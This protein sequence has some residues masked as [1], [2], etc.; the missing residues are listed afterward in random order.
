MPTVVRTVLQRS[1]AIN[2][3]RK[4]KNNAQVSAPQ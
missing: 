1:L 2:Y 4:G 3:V